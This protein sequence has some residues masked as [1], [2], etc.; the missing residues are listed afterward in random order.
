MFINKHN[1]FLS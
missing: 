1:G